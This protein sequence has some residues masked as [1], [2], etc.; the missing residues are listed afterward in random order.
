LGRRLRIAARDARRTRNAGSRP[1]HLTN[2]WK[3]HRK[4]GLFIYWWR[5]RRL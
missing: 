4:G 2:K 5:R 3:S 1:H